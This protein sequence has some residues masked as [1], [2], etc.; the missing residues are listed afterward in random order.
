MWQW[1]IF[2]VLPRYLF[3]SLITHEVILSALITGWLKSHIDEQ[4]LRET[5][6]S[7]ACLRRCPFKT[8]TNQSKCSTLW[9][10][11]KRNKPFSV[12]RPICL[13]LHLQPLPFSLSNHFIPSFILNVCLLNISQDRCL[14]AQ[15]ITKASKRQLKLIHFPLLRMMRESYRIKENSKKHWS[16]PL[17]SLRTSSD[18]MF[19][20]L[21]YNSSEL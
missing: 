17:P 11:R 7:Q 14:S 13:S 21:Y 18:M 3:V 1:L 4:A 19:I 9:T 8:G 5:Q 10:V 15:C 6:I 12:C 20:D 2:N 16:H